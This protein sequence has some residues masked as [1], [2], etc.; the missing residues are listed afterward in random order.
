MLRRII[1]VLLGLLLLLIII[2]AVGLA[3]AHV[4]I[5][6]ERTPLPTAQDIVNSAGGEDRPIRLSIINTASQTMPRSAVLERESDPRPNEPY[7]M[8]HP[9]FVLEWADGRMLL[10]DTG[11]DRA[12]VVSFGWPLETF[13]SA[14][15]IQPM[16]SVAERLGEER[17]RLQ[18]V[19]F[20]HL[21][22]DHTGGILELCRNNVNK[23]RVFMSEAQRERP[24]HTTKPGLQYLRE[25]GCVSEESLTPAPLMAVNGFPGVYVVAA[26]GHTPGS[27]LIIAHVKVDSGLRTY[28]FV[29]DIVNNIDGIRADIP[30]P[31]L[32]RLLVVPEDDER[33]A[34]LRHFLRGL[35]ADN[36]VTLVV[37]HD[38]REIEAIGIPPWQP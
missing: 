15:P 7:V 23:V 26:G 8:S 22:T 30:K 19:I 1:L 24:N 6:R 25:A 32:Y 9:S 27:Q 17:K 3:S 16:L 38:Q 2:V 36:G 5:R 31:Y 21:H 13:A 11:M 37:A 34:E 28:A 20:S 33:Q 18:A 4:A 14:V 10:I 29:G 12:Q 35:E